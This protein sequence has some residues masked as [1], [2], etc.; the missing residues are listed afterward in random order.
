MGAFFL[1][2]DIDTVESWTATI[3]DE[4]VVAGV[5]L[6]HITEKAVFGEVTYEISDQLSITAG[7]R[8]FD[9]T[10]EFENPA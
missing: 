5:Y 2:Q 3:L 1:E 6:P 4:S 9:N 10:F 7:G 8:W